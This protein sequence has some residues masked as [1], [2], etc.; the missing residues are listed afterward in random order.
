MQ[1]RPLERGASPLP[2]G[3]LL[4]VGELL[5]VCRTGASVSV[6]QSGEDRLYGPAPGVRLQFATEADYMEAAAVCDGLLLTIHNRSFP[7]RAT[8]LAGVAGR[9]SAHFRVTG[10][11]TH[12]F[13]D[14]GQ[15]TRNDHS[16]IFVAYPDGM[17]NT[18][19]FEDDSALKA[20]GLAISPSFLS[21]ELGLE[22]RRL[23]EPLRAW[24]EDGV[25]SFHVEELPFTA[26]MHQAVV[27]LLEAPYRGRLRH[28]H[29][30]ARAL[31]LACMVGQALIS[32]Q[33][34]GY[35]IRLT[36]REVARLHELREML[37][38]AFHEPPTIAA[39]ARLAGMNR[40]KLQY[41]FRQLFRTTIFDYCSE[42]R[43]QRARELLLAGD[44]NVSQV[45]HAVGYD[46]PNN[47]TAAFKRRFG[48]LPSQLRR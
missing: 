1:L 24:I 46:H 39:L 13:G 43:M 9:F 12:R 7:E 31:E 38:E 28:R 14:V 22:P 16:C 36:P 20:V 41:G 10:R 48:H 42:L 18:E 45:A 8:T 15:V 5:D 3:P 6:G 27:D 47:F 32:R 37:T 29:A 21:E 25:Q 17:L 44:L 34:G 26:G 30:E 35:E 4:D 23:P 19:A 2:N 11:S 40:T 33:E